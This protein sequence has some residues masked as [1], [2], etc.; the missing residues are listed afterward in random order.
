MKLRRL[1]SRHW[2]RC[3]YCRLHMADLK[4][5]RMKN[6][7]SA[8]LKKLIVGAKMLQLIIPV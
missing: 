3:H 7:K 6:F 2:N 8:Q 5:I 4:I 1:R